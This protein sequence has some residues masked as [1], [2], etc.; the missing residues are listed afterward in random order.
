MTHF[1]INGSWSNKFIT[2]RWN[3]EAL[4]AEK[5][6]FHFFSVLASWWEEMWRKSKQSNKNPAHRA[7]FLFIIIFYYFFCIREIKR[8]ET[9]K[10]AREGKIDIFSTLFHLFSH[11]TLS[12]LF[13]GHSFFFSIYFFLFSWFFLS[14]R[15]KSF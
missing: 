5:S 7:F 4:L 15:E 8:T 9:Q 1:L 2:H 10:I 13:K 12:L 14:L 11:L 6:F 3:L